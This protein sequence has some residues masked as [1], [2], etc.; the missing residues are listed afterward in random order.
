[1]CTTLGLEIRAARSSAGLSQRDTGRFAGMDHSIVGKIER[2]QY[3]AV[4]LGQLSRLSAAVGLDLSVRT[5]AG[6]DAIRD[7]GHVRLL[8][9]LR[10]TLH[11]SF[12]WR[13]EVPLP[14]PG[15]QRAWDAVV[16][17]GSTAIGV[18]AETVFRDVQAQTRRLILKQRDGGLDRMILL[19][20]DTRRNRAALAT[21][22][23]SLRETFPLDTRAILGTLRAGSI[24]E[25][26][27][28]LRL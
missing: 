7:A 23:E 13:S 26:S 1:M 16:S 17:R 22:R 10:L 4:T 6:G 20:A 28:I 2:G 3:P 19:V 24:P 27:G 9:R 5:Y 21:C 14:G 12:T 15:D 25:R 11:P 18:E 8:E